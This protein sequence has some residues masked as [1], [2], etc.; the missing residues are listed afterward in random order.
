MAM[1]D[2]HLVNPDYMSV[3]QKMLIAKVATLDSEQQ[4]HPK[5]KVTRL[6]SATM[7][8]NAVHFVKNHDNNTP[9]QPKQVDRDDKDVTFETHKVNEVVNQ[10]TVSW[11]EKPHAGYR[12]SIKQITFDNDTH[13]ATV[14][15]ELHY[16]DPA[17]LYAQVITEPKATSYVPSEYEVSLERYM[18][19][20]K[21]TAVEMRIAN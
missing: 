6:N 7:L 19:P 21:D 11:G 20:S 9:E 2:E 8:Y 15:Y 10:V 4:F 5:K 12:L 13:K 3:I 18:A 16:P 17:A 14:Y 1:Q